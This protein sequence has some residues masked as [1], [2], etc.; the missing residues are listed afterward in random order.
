MYINCFYPR[1]W[2]L[3]CLANDPK[4]LWIKLAY[5]R[6]HHHSIP[7]L[8]VSSS[9]S[10]ALKTIWK[11][12]V[13]SNVQLFVWRLLLNRIHVRYELKRC[14][15]IIGSHDTIFLF[16]F[17]HENYAHLFIFGLFSAPVWTRVQAR[18]DFE[19]FSVSSPILDL[20]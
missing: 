14:R 16:L 17:K 1:G 20:F 11:S 6:M 12:K 8:T 3:Y 4:G 10:L 19:G 15:M 2:W 18:L 13:P 7:V 5:T 9:L